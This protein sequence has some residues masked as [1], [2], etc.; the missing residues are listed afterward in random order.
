[1][2]W[3]RHMSWPVTSPV[4]GSDRSR[5]FRA[6]GSPWAIFAD[7]APASPV[8]WLSSSF[9][10]LSAVASVHGAATVAEAYELAP[11]IQEAGAAAAGDLRV[12]N[13]G[14]IDRYVNLWGE[15]PMRYLGS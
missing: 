2:G 14:T 11:L 4:I 7:I 9:P 10:A 12:V 13:S 5:Y 3:R 6:N 15:K 8:E 1:M